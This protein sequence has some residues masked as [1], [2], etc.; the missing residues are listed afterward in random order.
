[1]AGRR[2]SALAAET[3]KRVTLELGGKSANVVLDDA[4][5][6]RAVK[7]GVANAFMN[8]GQACSAWTRLLVPADRH[9]EALEVAAAAAAK[10]EPGDPA[11]T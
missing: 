6:T 7:I 11:L 3:V 8:N 9:D 4:D 1:R 2:V 10:Y 5:L